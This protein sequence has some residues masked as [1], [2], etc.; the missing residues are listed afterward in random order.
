LGCIPM[1]RG[2]LRIQCRNSLLGVGTGRA[3]E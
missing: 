1:V 2:P 3:L